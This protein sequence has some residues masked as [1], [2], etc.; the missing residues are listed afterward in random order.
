MTL[1]SKLHEG[2]LLAGLDHDETEVLR[3]RQHDSNATIAKA[4]AVPML[5]FAALLAWIDL[6]RAAAG[7]LDGSPLYLALAVS[8]LVYAIGV[9]PSLLMWVQHRM[10]RPWRSRVLMAHIVVL[11]G[12]LVMMAVLGIVERG[13]LVL[14]AVA[15][16]V[17]NL[18]YQVRLKPRLAFN[19]VAFIACGAAVLMTAQPGE[20]IAVLVR[21]TEFIALMTVI[22]IVGGL[23]N[24]QR[25]ASLLA[26]H[27]LTQLAMLDALTG[28][29]SRRRLD[30]V[31]RQELAAVARGRSLSVVM[32]DVDHFKSVN[33]RFGHD[34]GDEVLRGV[35]RV[36]QQ[37]ARLPDV[38]GRWGGEE[39]LV[40]CTDTPADGAAVLAERLAQSLRETGFA[41]VGRVTASFGVAQAVVGDSPRDLVDRADRALYQAKQAGR[42]RVVVAEPPRE[43]AA[44]ARRLSSAGGSPAPQANAGGSPA[45]Q[46]SAGGGPAPQA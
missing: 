4:L 24:R 29:A 3:S 12:S 25:M 44:L 10:S 21:A 6:K 33:D 42:D 36:L 13:G 34:N 14:L 30:H 45:P 31:L 5:V 19:L 43:A 16:L 7:L 1:L 35:A 46:A 27:R 40:V 23:H 18:M 32:L 11:S 8:H 26:E 17:G 22:A 15:L 9:V 2:P 28:V 41:V 20:D 39:F 38:I 37:G